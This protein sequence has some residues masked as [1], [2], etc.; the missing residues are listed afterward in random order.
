VT[1]RQ[2]KEGALGEV[3]CAKLAETATADTATSADR[4]A[5][6]AAA[7]CRLSARRRRAGRLPV[8]LEAGP[9]LSARSGADGVWVKGTTLGSGETM[10]VQELEAGGP[11]E[12]F[13]PIIIVSALGK[14]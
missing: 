11:A 4:V 2:I 14:D 5:T 13:L 8:L 10:V 7:V 6:A 3:P 1:G 9:L 12:E